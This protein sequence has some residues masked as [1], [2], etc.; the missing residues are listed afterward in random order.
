MFFKE[1][2]I[3]YVIENLSKI[4]STI[5]RA[6][7]HRPW[8]KLGLKIGDELETTTNERN[9]LKTLAESL[10]LDQEALDRWLKIDDGLLG[11]ALLTDD[12][13]VK[14]VITNASFNN[15]DTDISDNDEQEDVHH[16][17]NN[18]NNIEA[19]VDSTTNNEKDSGIKVDDFKS[20]A[21]PTS[22]GKNIIF[23]NILLCCLVLIFCDLILKRCDWRMLGHRTLDRLAT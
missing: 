23:K 7:I 14:K 18:N 2:D 11:Y 20:M 12:E 22:K 9:E 4:W 6:V 16:K 13:I 10:Q 17:N 3:K 19:L 15:T 1:L 21:I 8:K 5:D